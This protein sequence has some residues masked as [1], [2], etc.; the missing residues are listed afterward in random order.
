MQSFIRLSVVQYML[1]YEYTHHSPCSLLILRD[2][3]TVWCSTVTRSE[4]Y[5]PSQ[6]S[7]NDESKTLWHRRRC[8]CRCTVRC[9][10][11]AWR[12]RDK[13]RMWVRWPCVCDTNVLSVRSTV[14]AFRIEMDCLMVC[15]VLLSCWQ[16]IHLLRQGLVS[17]W[18]S[19]SQRNT[20]LFDWWPHS[21]SRAN[22][23]KN[24]EHI[25]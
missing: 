10:Q 6:L 1:V 12:E 21:I 3:W 9:I 20:C 7:T 8:L 17:V 13:T 18:R 2:G 5:H 16:C 15:Y 4:K 23:V 22:L 25:N 11:C 14:L 24:L 19:L